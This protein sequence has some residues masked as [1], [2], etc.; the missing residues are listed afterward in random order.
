LKVDVV[1]TGA[2][3]YTQRGISMRAGSQPTGCATWRLDKLHP[4]IADV[5]AADVV[6]TDVVAAGDGG[7]HSDL[8]FL[9]ADSI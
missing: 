6:A 8:T 4:I 9:I 2:P 3:A 1:E 7:V 5:V